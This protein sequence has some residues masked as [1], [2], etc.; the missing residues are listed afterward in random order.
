[1]FRTRAAA[2]AA[3]IIV[4]ALVVLPGLHPDDRAYVAASE[5][6]LAAFSADLEGWAHD[7][8]CALCRVTSQFRTAL[9]DPADRNLHAAPSAGLRLQDTGEI[10]LS[11]PI[12]RGPRAR[13]PPSA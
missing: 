2:C 13:A 8:N 7:P 11:T 1:V 12:L 4:L 5:P 3:L 9:H 10:A 6:G